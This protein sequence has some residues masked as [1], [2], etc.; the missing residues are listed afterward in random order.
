MLRN[1]FLFSEPASLL[2]TNSL[3]IRYYNK[4]SLH[5]T[6]LTMLLDIL[7]QVPESI[8]AL[9]VSSADAANHPAVLLSRLVPGSFVD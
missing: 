8:S 6:L 9:N 3:L 4:S 7:L 5:G 2:T 1:S